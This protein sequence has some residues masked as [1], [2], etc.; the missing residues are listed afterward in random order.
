MRNGAY[1]DYNTTAPRSEGV[2]GAVARQ[3][4]WRVNETAAACA[5]RGGSAP[6]LVV[7]RHPFSRPIRRLRVDAQIVDVG[8]KPEVPRVAV[9]RGTLRLRPETVRAIAGRTIPK[10]D[11]L[12]TAQVAALHAVKRTSELLPLCHPIP[13]S[14]AR[15]SF[16][17][18]DDA[19]HLT[20]TVEAHYRTG[21]E[22]EALTAA[23]IGLLCVWDMVK[24]LE[25]DDR[26]GYPDA[27]LE[28]LHVVR[29]TKGAP[30]GAT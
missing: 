13:V 29:K 1:H 5:P 12:A 18:G 9:A 3:T 16:E 23:A 24:P 2:R 4:V 22:M 17:L 19:L 26:G 30:G 28:D 7:H 21:V 11:V 8:R 20:V 15:A 10:G 25:K 6:T 14:H 27:R